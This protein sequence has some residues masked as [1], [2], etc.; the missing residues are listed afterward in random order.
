MNIEIQHILSNAQ[1][2]WR[3]IWASPP[4][5]I[6]C[7]IQSTRDLIEAL[8]LNNGRYIASEASLS[9]DGIDQAIL[10]DAEMRGL[11]RWGLSG[12]LWSFDLEVYLTKKGRN[13]CG[14][15]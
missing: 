4:E 15:N 3:S 8:R 10:D 6:D 5:Q 2:M 13:A 1:S 11:I 7:S 14:L 12:G 9:P